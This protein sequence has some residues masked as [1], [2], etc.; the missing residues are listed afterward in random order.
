MTSLLDQGHLPHRKHDVTAVAI[1]SA[2]GEFRGWNL[3]FSLS[4]GYSVIE[5]KIK[6]PKVLIFAAKCNSI[7]RTNEMF[8]LT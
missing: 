8:L 3:V 4:L 5:N 2:A 1:R 6:K 7:F